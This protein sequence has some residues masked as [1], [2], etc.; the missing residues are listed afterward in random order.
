VALSYRAVLVRSSF[1]L[2]LSLAL[3]SHERKIKYQRKG[4]VSS[5]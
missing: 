2:Q 1:G 4:V 3:G 5:D